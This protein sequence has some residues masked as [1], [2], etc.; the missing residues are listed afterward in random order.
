MAKLTDTKNLNDI[1]FLRLS[2]IFDINFPAAFSLLRERGYLKTI[3]YSIPEIEEAQIVRK[4]ID[5]YLNAIETRSRN[6]AV[7]T[8]II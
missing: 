3:L 7:K 8:D 6:K 2:W 5:S 1:K 4:H